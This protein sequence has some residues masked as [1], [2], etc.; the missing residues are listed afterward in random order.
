MADEILSFIERFYAALEGGDSNAVMQFLSDDLKWSW[1]SE[2]T[3]SQMRSM[4]LGRMVHLPDPDVLIIENQRLETYSL[5]N[6]VVSVGRELA[7][8]KSRNR[9]YETGWTHTM[10]VKDNLIIEQRESSDAPKLI[11]PEN[12]PVCIPESILVR[13]K[14][15]EPIQEF[16][17]LSKPVV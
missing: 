14:K 2:A 9:F 16:G 17:T 8:V 4:Q 12:L 6:K 7:L 5:D 13:V 11:S 3:P 10:L 15:G 1:H